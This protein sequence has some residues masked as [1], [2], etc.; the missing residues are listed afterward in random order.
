M[1]L[2]FAIT[3]FEILEKAEVIVCLLPLVMGLRF[4]CLLPPGME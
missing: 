2:W 3:N 1:K 4:F